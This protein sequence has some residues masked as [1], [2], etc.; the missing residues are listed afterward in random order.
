MSSIQQNANDL[1][2]TA[3]ATMHAAHE[4]LDDVKANLRTMKQ[5]AQE[6]LQSSLK[7]HVSVEARTV[8]SS[9]KNRKSSRVENDANMQDGNRTAADGS[10]KNSGDS[11]N[12]ELDVQKKASIQI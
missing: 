5:S 4:N 8:P 10:G 1:Q 12:S 2:D 7:E 6:T 9:V 3:I 11:G